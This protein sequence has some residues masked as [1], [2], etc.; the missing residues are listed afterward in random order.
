MVFYYLLVD[1]KGLVGV[2]IEVIILVL[3]LVIKMGGGKFII[4]FESYIVE[5][6]GGG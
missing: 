1:I 3:Y 6:F 4:I 2:F 5:M